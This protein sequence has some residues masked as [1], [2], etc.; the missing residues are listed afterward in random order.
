MTTNLQPPYL[1]VTFID[2][3]TSPWTKSE[4][5]ELGYEVAGLPPRQEARVALQDHGRWQILR[6][7]DGVQGDW[8]GDFYSAAEALASLQ[9]HLPTA[10]AP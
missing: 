9:A 2:A 1:T 7:R 6:V 8:D 3:S 10:D 5:V 4:P